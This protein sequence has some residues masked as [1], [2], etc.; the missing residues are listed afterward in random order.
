[1]PIQTLTKLQYSKDR[2]G[3]FALY[4]YNLNSEYHSPPTWF[5]DKPK[6]EGEITTEQARTIAKAAFMQGREVRITDGGD[7]LVF[8][9]KGKKVLYGAQFW[10]EIMPKNVRAADKRS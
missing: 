2:E 6:Y 8:H 7:L 10:E 5:M 1:M 3:P 9:A 4:I